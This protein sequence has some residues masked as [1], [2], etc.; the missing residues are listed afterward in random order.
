MLKPGHSLVAT[1]SQNGHLQ[2]ARFLFG[3]LI[4]QGSSSSGLAENCNSVLPQ[5]DSFKVPFQQSTS[6]S[7]VLATNSLNGLHTSEIIE[8]TSKYLSY[9]SLNMY[10]AQV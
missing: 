4:S 1:F 6:A 8:L 10:L 7:V 9:S 3:D 2:R 5:G